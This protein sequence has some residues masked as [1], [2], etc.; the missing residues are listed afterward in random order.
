MR[1]LQPFFTLRHSSKQLQ[2]LQADLATSHAESCKLQQENVSARKQLVL[3]PL[4]TDIPLSP[5]GHTASS[6]VSSLPRNPPTLSKRPSSPRVA[7]SKCDTAQPSLTAIVRQIPS[8]A[9][10]IS[11]KHIHIFYETELRS[12]LSKFS[13]TVC[14]GFDSLDV[15]IMRNPIPVN[16]PAGCKVRRARKAFLHRIDIALQRFRAPIHNAAAHFFDQ[17]GHIDLE[18]LALYNLILP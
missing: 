11:F 2:Q 5:S 15:S 3:K 13:I 16:E 12:Q 4:T 9:E 8:P 10:P 14:E 18:Y 6:T 1:L 7:K 17:S